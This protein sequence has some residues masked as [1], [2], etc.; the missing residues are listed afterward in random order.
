M[1]TITAAKS[2]RY[3]LIT[4]VLQLS[5]NNHSRVAPVTCIFFLFFADSVDNGYVLNFSKIIVR[6]I[7]ATILSRTKLLEFRRHLLNF[8]SLLE[9]CPRDRRAEDSKMKARED[10]FAAFCVCSR[11]LMT[12]NGEKKS[13]YIILSWTTGSSICRL[14]NKS[15][16]KSSPVV[17]WIRIPFPLSCL[18]MN[19]QTIDSKTALSKIPND[20]S[21]TEEPAELIWLRKTVLAEHHSVS[22]V[23]D[24]PGKRISKGSSSASG[25]SPTA[26]W[27]FIRKISR[28]D[29]SPPP[30]TPKIRQSALADLN[31][32]VHGRDHGEPTLLCRKAWIHSLIKV[33]D[34]PRKRATGSTDQTGGTVNQDIYTSSLTCFPQK[35]Q[36][37]RARRT[38]DTVDHLT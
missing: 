2:P 16:G 25:T 17:F 13:R 8:Y 6:E 9:R 12:D 11:G 20:R 14:E 38:R 21:H 35:F 5:Q 30:D 10:F 3:I 32:I 29:A 22:T 23:E 1:E 34:S 4:R 18:Y 24:L 33:G 15:A 26:E 28:N 7:R 36:P 37:C 27:E 31:C 19:L